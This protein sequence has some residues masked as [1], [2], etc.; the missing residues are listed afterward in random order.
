MAWQAVASAAAPIV[1]GFLGNVLGAGDRKRA[2][3]LR[4]E[5][6]DEYGNINPEV[7]QSIQAEQQG[8]SSLAGYEDD[9]ANM[10]AQREALAAL[11]RQYQSGGMT[12]EDR[13]NTEMMRQ[14]TGRQ[15]KADREAVL[16][17]AAAR[18][19]IGSGD[20]LASLLLGQQAGADRANMAGMQTAAAASQ[21]AQ[22]AAAGMGQMAGNMRNQDFSQAKAQA[23]AA[24]EIN[25]F[26]TMQRQS[27]NQ[28]NMDNRQQNF[29]NRMQLT[30][31][32]N[33]ARTGQASSLDQSAQRTADMWAGVGSGVGQGAAGYGQSSNNQQ[34]L[35]EYAKKGGR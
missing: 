11:Q 24:D 14:E 17:G 29:Q 2:A 12:A 16:Q 32:K 4:Q 19:G 20:V 15:S 1:G 35:Q 25:R 33:Q 34:W 3:A 5:M 30:G 9:P 22:N 13:L 23:D 10:Q 6:V 18:G 7:L 8:A 31:A 27:T 28:Y 21:R 26:N